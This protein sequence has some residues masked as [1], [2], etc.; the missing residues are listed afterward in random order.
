[1]NKCDSL[2][3]PNEDYKIINKVKELLFGIYIIKRGDLLNTNIFKIGKTQRSLNTR[4]NEYSIPNT[5]VLF[6]IPVN[7]V[8]AL[9][10]LII[11]QLK[12]TQY[13]VFRNDL[14]S[15]YFEGEYEIIKSVIINLCSQFKINHNYNIGK[16]IEY[17]NN[18][19]KPTLK[20]NNLLN[21]DINTDNNIHN[22][23]YIIE[24][25]NKT[26][27]NN[28]VCKRCGKSFQYDNLLKRHLNNKILCGPLFSNISIDVLLQELIYK[29][30]THIIN[31]KK[32][33]ICKYCNK[34]LTTAAGKSFHQKN[35]KMNKD[36]KNAIYN[37][38]I[39][40]TDN[41]V[42][43][44][45]NTNNNNIEFNTN[46]TNYIQK[47]PIKNEIESNDVLITDKKYRIN[48]SMNTNDT[49]TIEE[50]HNIEVNFDKA[51]IKIF[52]DNKI[53]YKA[54]YRDVELWYNQT[55]MLGCLSKGKNNN[56]LIP[57]KDIKYM[58]D[59]VYDNK[60]ELIN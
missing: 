51:D 60:I 25:N 3:T 11:F 42:N 27:K 39:N 49:I 43:I 8:D 28:S 20:Y 33:Y 19:H 9:E 2:S 14:G 30:P 24:T 29:K 45:N 40:N 17:S 32:Y 5:Y 34:H 35:C 55:N 13:I 46:E 26:H 22:D 23:N 54:T 15:E 41:S 37:S 12:N 50:E 16:L 47:S 38:I 57:I 59:S 56:N 18:N 52:P 1:M 36:N 7:K 6:Y 4:H 21:N 53:C 44:Q 58:I 48:N 31:N 10:Q